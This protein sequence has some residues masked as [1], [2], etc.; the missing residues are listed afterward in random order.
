M[1]ANHISGND[2]WDLLVHG[3]RAANWVIILWAA[4]RA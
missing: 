3:A 4:R 2:P 1:L